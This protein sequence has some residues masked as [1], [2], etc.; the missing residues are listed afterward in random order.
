MSLVYSSSAKDTNNNT[1]ITPAKTAF[2]ALY[3][4]SKP[5]AIYTNPSPATVAETGYFSYQNTPS[6]LL[7]IQILIS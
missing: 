5:K 6:K 4:S 7:L 2:Q 1:I 3:P